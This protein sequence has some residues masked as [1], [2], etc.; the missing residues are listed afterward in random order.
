MIKISWGHA[1]DLKRN[2]ERDLNNSKIFK[3]V[4]TMDKIDYVETKN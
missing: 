4:V 1:R 3:E 2:V